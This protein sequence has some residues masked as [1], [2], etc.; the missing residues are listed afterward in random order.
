MPSRSR[1]DDEHDLDR[2]AVSL[3]DFGFR[4]GWICESKPRSR[5]IHSRSGKTVLAV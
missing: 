1:E 4:H 3:A 5:R 2:R